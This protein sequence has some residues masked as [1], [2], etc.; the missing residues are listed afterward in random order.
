[1]LESEG[2]G[3]CSRLV[4][5]AVE[6]ADGTD[7]VLF[8]LSRSSFSLTALSRLALCIFCEVYLL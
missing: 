8:W 2:D 6:D 5:E 4:V 7:E 3:A 1:M